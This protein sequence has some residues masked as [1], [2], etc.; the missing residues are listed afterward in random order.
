MKKIFVQK[1]KIFTLVLGILFIASTAF[2]P[3]VSFG[4]TQAN[5]YVDP[6]NGNDTNSGFSFTSPFKTID[7]AQTVVR[8]INNS[9]TGDIYVF[10]LGGN[11]IFSSTITF[12][13]LDGGS[14]G[15]K[16]IY[17]AF[18]NE[19]P[20]ISGDKTITGWTLNDAAKN[21]YKASTGYTI[22]T[23]QLFVNGNR[24]IRA[25]SVDTLPYTTLV[26]DTNSVGVGYVSPKTEILGWDNI[27]NLEMVY[28][29]KWTNSRCGVAS[30]AAQGFSVMITMKQP[31][32][33][34]MSSR[35]ITNV[36]TQS[37][38]F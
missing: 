23:R 33:R 36:K 24:A 35:G 11:Y 21:I 30:V 5:Y 18:N 17:K 16:V 27:T 7:K 10:L 14:N 4:G 25:R 15:Y 2:I 19:L 26:K 31:G 32:F 38:N 20:I 6:A 22:D 9:M 13:E 28:K 29:E 1:R 8:I 34:Y 3:T 37:N 12:T